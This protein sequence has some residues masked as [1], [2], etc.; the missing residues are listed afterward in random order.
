MDVLANEEA[1]VHAAASLPVLQDCIKRQPDVF[2]EEFHA[3]YEAFKTQV[4]LFQETPQ[5]PNVAFDEL[6]MFIAQTG[7]FYGVCHDLG[8]LIMGLIKTYIDVGKHLHLKTFMRCL[9]LLDNNNRLDRDVLYTWFLEMLERETDDDV[10]KL[11]IKQLIKGLSTYVTD[12]NQKK[13]W[14]K[15]FGENVNSNE[16]G[17]VYIRRLQFIMITLYLKQIW[18]DK[19]IVNAIADGTLSKIPKVVEYAARFILGDMKRMNIDLS[20]S[21]NEELSTEDLKKRRAELIATITKEISQTR[22]KKNNQRR[23]ESL[24]EKLRKEMEEEEDNRKSNEKNYFITF[25]VMDKLYNPYSLC[26]KIC[27]RVFHS[28]RRLSFK[29]KLLLNTVCGRL[30]GRFKLWIPN[31]FASLAKYIRPSQP[32]ITRILAVAAQAVHEHVPAEQDLQPLTR[33]I[34][35]QF[36]IDSCPPEAIAVG[37]NTIREIFTRN[38]DALTPE[39]VEDLVQFVRQGRDNSVRIAASSLRNKVREISPELLTRRDKTKSVKQATNYGAETDSTSRGTINERKTIEGLDLLFKLKSC[40]MPNKKKR[41]RDALTD[42]QDAQTLQSSKILSQR[43]FAALKKLKFKMK[44]AQILGLSLSEWLETNKD[45][46]EILARDVFGVE[47]DDTQQDGSTGETHHYNAEESNDSTT[48]QSESDDEIDYEDTDDLIDE[49]NEDTHA[50]GSIRKKF[51]LATDIIDEPEETSTSPNDD[52]EALSSDDDEL[53]EDEEDDENDQET[54]LTGDTLMSDKR[55]TRA[56]SRWKQHE[57][58]A[59]AKN[60]KSDRGHGGRYGTLAGVSNRTS[61]RNKPMAMVRKKREVMEKTTRCA[62]DKV[63][64][65]KSHIRTLKTS[66]KQ[67]LRPRR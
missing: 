43:D 7:H 61:A 54:I 9:T 37:L 27:F 29:L 67:K 66:V 45:N 52:D 6:V 18:T 38:N 25:E 12:S 8:L 53:E 56:E 13:K 57:E 5:K 31:F 35:D 2:R 30:M 41:P 24:K 32:E 62:R 10:P 63:A 11:I 42:S 17:T 50:D 23:I 58:R 3:Q 39:L 26:E 1:P 14:Q 64:A 60:K 48:D 65:L 47:D 59:L 40:L 21:S 19:Y 34:A 33:L 16:K 4:S 46:M 15:V 20:G 28:N 44:A 55:S 36:I 49:Q 22:K 51:K